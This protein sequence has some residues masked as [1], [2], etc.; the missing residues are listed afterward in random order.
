MDLEIFVMCGEGNKFLNSMETLR[1]CDFLVGEGGGGLV[2][3]LDSHVSLQ[4]NEK[5]YWLFKKLQEV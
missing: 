4:W 2:S 5:L 3:S 1:T